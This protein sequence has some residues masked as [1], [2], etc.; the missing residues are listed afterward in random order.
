MCCYHNSTRIII[1]ITI[2]NTREIS[3][4]LLLKNLPNKTDIYRCGC[5]IRTQRSSGYEPDEIDH[6]SNPQV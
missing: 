5:R 2:K 1:K 3:I 4:L 6:F